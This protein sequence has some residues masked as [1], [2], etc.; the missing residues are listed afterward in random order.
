M[1]LSDLDANLNNLFES[2][3][4]KDFFIDSSVDFVFDS[5]CA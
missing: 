1:E 4:N 2:S 3:S 5:L